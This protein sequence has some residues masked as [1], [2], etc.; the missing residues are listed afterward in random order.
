MQ[1]VAPCFLVRYAR[2]ADSALE[3]NGRKYFYFISVV[4]WCLKLVPLS[5]R[6]DSALG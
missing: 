5:Q 4:R 2:A 1:S 3:K 6:S